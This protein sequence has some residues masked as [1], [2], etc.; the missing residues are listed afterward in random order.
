MTSKIYLAIILSDYQ[1]IGLKR[2]IEHFH[3][4]DKIIAIK[5][6][7]ETINENFYGKSIKFPKNV[8]RK[9]F[10]NKH[11]F[12]I[13]FL[14]VLLKNFFYKK[15]FIFG[16]PI[17]KFCL[18]LSYF[19]NGKNQFYLDDGIQ[20][21]HFNYNLLKKNSTL[22]TVYKIKTPS[23]IKNIQY[24]LKYVKKRKK[25]RNEI[26]FI[27]SPLIAVNVLSRDKFIKIMKVISKKH[28]KFYYYPHRDC[29]DDLRLLPKN[30][31]IMKR[32]T[33]VE[34]FVM[35]YKY[36]FRL[37]Y[38]LGSSSLI[39]IINYYKKEN[40]RVFDINEWIDNTGENPLHKTKL[41]IYHDYLKKIKISIIKIKKINI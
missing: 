26:L 7:N 33:S 13:Y 25:T 16:N 10:P 35:N 8:K 22:F 27:G 23:K 18:F 6:T 5:Y 14:L 30:F 32:K 17:S 37:I 36:N 3:I 1:E 20:T 34:Q 31:K 12:F 39:E 11:V 38:S 21:I 24:F 41:K 29:S 9:F 40:L 4:K 15:K 28:K 2:F 19:I